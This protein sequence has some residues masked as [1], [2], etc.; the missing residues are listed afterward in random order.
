MSIVDAPALMLAAAVG[1]LACLLGF[2]HGR[3]RRR[4]H[5]M[6][7][8]MGSLAAVLNFVEC[9]PAFMYAPASA[10]IT[11]Y[12]SNFFLVGCG[13][14]ILTGVPY[15]LSYALGCYITART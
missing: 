3:S 13:L 4:W 5:W 7:A 6:L 10:W 2:W 8:T 14:W 12:M 15:L 11:L 1:V 9:I